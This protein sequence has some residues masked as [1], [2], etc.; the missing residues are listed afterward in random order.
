MSQTKKPGDVVIY[1]VGNRE[2]V[3]LVIYA[4]STVSTHLGEDD[5]PLLH[6]VYVDPDVKLPVGQAGYK[7]FVRTEYDVVH[8][9]HS[10]DADYIRQH[11]K[12]AGP[13]RWREEYEN[14][15]QAKAPEPPATDQP[16]TPE[17]AAQSNRAP[18]VAIPQAPP[19]T[20]PQAPGSSGAASPLGST[21]AGP[22]D[23]GSSGA[24]SPLGS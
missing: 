6:L 7:D 21:A 16:A 15:P 13:G 12:D 11:G 24:S 4:H 3:A 14:P 19:A 1:T 22:S 5:E 9:S 18:V 10:F 2:F 23:Q 17:A 20:A 8:Q